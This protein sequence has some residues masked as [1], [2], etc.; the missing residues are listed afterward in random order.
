MLF[1]V[2]TCAHSSYLFQGVELDK[3]K[4]EEISLSP[5]LISL[6]QAQQKLKG[7]SGSQETTNEGASSTAAKPEDGAPPP[8]LPELPDIKNAPRRNL[9]E[10]GRTVSTT[11]IGELKRKPSTLK[12]SGGMNIQFTCFTCALAINI[13]TIH[14]QNE[15]RERK[16]DQP[17]K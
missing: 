4:D 3:I 17:A 10:R 1:I 9:R 5:H 2:V 11:A 14:H 8:K 16:S 7:G 13:H 12:T 15:L 6:K